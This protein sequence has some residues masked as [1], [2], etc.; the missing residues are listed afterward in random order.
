M[1]CVATSAT[2]GKQGDERGSMDKVRTFASDIFGEDFDEPNPIYGTSA[3]P[4]L[5]QPAHFVQLLLNILMQ[6]QPCGT[7]IKPM[8]GNSWG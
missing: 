8:S 3:E 4:V 6:L 5:E 1:T 7:T 2:L